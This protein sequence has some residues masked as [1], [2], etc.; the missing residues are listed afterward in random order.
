MKNQTCPL[1]D[2]AATYGWT[3]RPDSGKIFNCPT[4]TRFFIDAESEQE[5]LGVAEVARTEIRT[6]LSQQAQ[7]TQRNHIY[8]IRAPKPDEVGGSGYGAPQP[9]IS[10]EWIELSS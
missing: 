4:C 2:S 9:V 8:V 10:T 6:K 3:S 5:L 7:S 1:C